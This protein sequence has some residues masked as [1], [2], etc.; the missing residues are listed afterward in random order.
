MARIALMPAPSEA[1]AAALKYRRDIDGLRAVAVLAV[2]GFHGFPTW[3]PGGFVGVDVFFVISG[4]LISHQLFTACDRGTFSIRDF[5]VRRIRR[6]F[7]ALLLVLMATAAFGWI[8]LTPSEF[9]SLQ[10]HLA[11]SAFF[12]NNFLLWYEAGYFD[13]Q[14][15]AKPLLH[16]WSLGVEEQFYIVWPWLI[17]W[18]WRK[19]VNRT[20]VIGIITVASLILSAVMVSNAS[21]AAAFYLPQSRLWQLA[22]GAWLASITLDAPGYIS[23]WI[24]GRREGKG[25]L[26]EHAMA[27][28]GVTLLVVAFTSLGQTPQALSYPGLPA[29]IP[30]V[31]AMLIV[32]A[33]PAAWLNR[34]LSHAVPVFIGLISY[35]LYLWHWPMLAFLQITEVGAV[36]LNM[37]LAAIGASFVLAT[38]SYLLIEKPIRSWVQPS[39][40][41]RAVAVAS[42][43][44]AVGLIALAALRTDSL[45]PPARVAATA[46][47]KV[48]N[49][50]GENGCKQRFP[51]KAGYCQ[52]SLPAPA[53][54][55]TVL[56]G[57]S[58]ASHFFPGLGARLA[59]KGESLA[60][61][62][63]YGCPPILG[64]AV[65]KET[66]D[67]PCS[68]VNRVA[69]A[70]ITGAPTVANVVL[71]FRGGI[72][73][74]GTTRI[75]STLTDP[76]A[77]HAALAATVASLV[78]HH[79]RVTIVLPVPGLPFEIEECFGRPWSLVPRPRRSPC[80]VDKAGALSQQ[81][82]FRHAVGEFAQRLH[83]T[84]V[85]PLSA[86][87]DETYC[88]AVLDGRPRYSDN[89]HLGMSGSKT[90]ATIFSLDQ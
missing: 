30:T 87:C 20:T 33:G 36:S 43:L 58:H 65:V 46:D 16:L 7:P 85:D 8:A 50:F 15:K 28:I 48:S 38:L 89:N 34:L 11:A 67:T 55:R 29:L 13:V 66:S 9:R 19:R 26:V 27:V 76:P 68:E 41:L 45:L 42:G 84:V 72:Y 35:P 78:E 17:F 61:F 3:L 57:D 77:L 79:K 86:L 74:G 40:P 73:S 25:R 88:W 52:E 2:I 53:P 12:S 62:G 24:A 75:G 82:E 81:A 37:T 39:Y 23:R 56:W 71:A 59:E 51:I 63:S 10:E 21:A 32:A 4:Y 70:A 22:A 80:A 49:G 31:G 83:V 18:C 5:Y 69:F 44:V 90:V 64:L 60:H 54:V 14:S 6:I 1:A 47:E